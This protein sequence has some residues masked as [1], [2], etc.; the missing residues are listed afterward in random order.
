MLI[1]TS[2]RQVSDR[3][4]RETG[5][6]DWSFGLSSKYT[7]RYVMAIDTRSK[8]YKADQYYSIKLLNGLKIS[9]GT[10][11]RTH[12]FWF[13]LCS[14]KHYLNHEYKSSHFVGKLLHRRKRLGD[15]SWWGTRGTY[16]DSHCSIKG[17]AKQNSKLI[18]IIS[19]IESCFCATLRLLSNSN[20]SQ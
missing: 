1:I 19:A 14:P 16:G 6:S 2:N 9:V 4:R 10:Y 17:L 7:I 11:R 18:C 20:N 13:S 5:P 12:R 8:W 15:P 3:C